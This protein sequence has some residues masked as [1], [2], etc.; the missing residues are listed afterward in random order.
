M[1]VGFTERHNYQ[2]SHI[3]CSYTIRLQVMTFLWELRE[4]CQTVT[5]TCTYKTLT[6]AFAATRTTRQVW[7]YMK[8]YAETSHSLLASIAQFLEEQDTIHMVNNPTIFTICSD[9][10]CH[11]Q[12]SQKPEKWTNNCLT[13]I[14]LTNCLAC[15]DSRK[16]NRFHRGRRDFLN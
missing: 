5:Q 3:S 9:I 8:Q 4:H 13:A 11:S 10:A 16:N 2:H 15:N 1:H 12:L 6:S 14:E 7:S